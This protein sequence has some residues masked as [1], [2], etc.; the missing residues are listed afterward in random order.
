MKIKAIV[1][2]L[3]LLSMLFLLRFYNEKIVPH[4]HYFEVNI[5]YLTVVITVILF[6]VTLFL[7]K[8]HKVLLSI[9][10]TIFL[11]VLLFGISF[12]GVRPYHII[13]EEVPKRME[14]L[15]S[16]LENNYPDRTWEV[17]KSDFTFDSHYLMLV[18]FDD[19]PD[20]IYRYL[21]SDEVIKGEKELKSS[22][23]RSPN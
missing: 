10:I 4:T 18:T 16:Y 19:E 13:Y 22:G 12:W 1:I 9:F 21:M 8:E 11:I 20:T 15:E 17:K 5:A 3:F 6:M 7:S 14:L 2:I 23:S